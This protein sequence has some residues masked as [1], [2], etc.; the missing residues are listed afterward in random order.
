METK[1]RGYLRQ[2]ALNVSTTPT[3][4]NSPDFNDRT[5]VRV[6][7]TTQPLAPLGGEREFAIMGFT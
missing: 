7:H 4:P 3:N 1:S 5:D 6:H 2:R